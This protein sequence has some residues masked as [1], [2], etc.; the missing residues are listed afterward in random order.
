[1][2][3]GLSRFDRSWQLI[4]RSFTVIGANRKLLL[5]PLV[6]FA[7]TLVI[8]LFFIAPAFL[9]SLGISL[10]E[11]ASWS[12]FAQRM[13][14]AGGQAGP[15][16]VP[17]LFI[18]G[19]YLV[20]MV[21]ATFFNV[22]F[23]NEI[24]KALRGE[25]VS[26]RSG[27]SFAF[28]RIGPILLW[29]LF[30]GIVGLIIRN[31]EQRFGWIGKIVMSLVGAVWSVSSVF[32]IPV[33]VREGEINPMEV[34]RRSAATLKKTW[35]ESLLGYVGLSFASTIAVLCSLYYWPRGSHWPS[36]STTPG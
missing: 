28:S 6:S 27:L 22:A 26:V 19:V 3:T 14:T 31:L 4:Q 9:L 34:L 23:Y 20:A 17:V 30:A 29:S 2:S 25:A 16:S 12:S 11:P 5:F 24:L 18:A 1:M 15:P 7:F 35:G 33:I 21:C 8:V 10:W 13:G 32:A 36:R